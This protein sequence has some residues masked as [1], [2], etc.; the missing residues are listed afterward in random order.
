MTPQTKQT[1]KQGETFWLDWGEHTLYVFELEKSRQTVDSLIKRIM[2]GHNFPAVPVDK[3]GEGKF[4][5]TRAVDENDIQVGG[6]NRAFAPYSLRVPFKCVLLG[7]QSENEVNYN[8]SPTV[9]NMFLVN[10]G[11]DLNWRKK[12]YGGYL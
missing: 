1:L 6:H 9:E 7:D 11:E 5:L 3:V 10:D 12:Y 2:A 8:G 4:T